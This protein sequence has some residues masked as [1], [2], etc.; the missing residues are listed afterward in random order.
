MLLATPTV[1]LG[2]LLPWTC[3][4]SS[5]LLQQSAAAAPYLGR[6][7]SPHSC[8]SW[9]SMWR[10]SSRPS[11]AH[12]ATAP[13][14]W[15]CIRLDNLKERKKVKVKSLSCLTLCDPMDCSPPG[16][17]MQFSRQEYWSGLPFPSPGDL[18]NPGIEPGSPELQAD[19]LL[20]EPPGKKRDIRRIPMFYLLLSFRR[21]VR[22]V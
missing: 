11:C 6:V 7:V 16:S 21:E 17:S 19:A 12:A 22:S 13:W 9:P 3:G 15:G 20:S 10:S 1:L 2:F 5:R 14:T 8:P 4:I 18:P